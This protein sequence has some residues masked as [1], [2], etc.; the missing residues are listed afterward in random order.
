MSKPLVAIS[1][2]LVILAAVFHFAHIA[3]DFEIVLVVLAVV[4]TDIGILMGE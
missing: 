1:L 4:L 3:T 2:V